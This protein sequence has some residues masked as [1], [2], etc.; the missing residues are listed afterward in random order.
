M[1]RLRVLTWCSVL[2]A[3][4]IFFFDR[5]TQTTLARGRGLVLDKAWLTNSA[6]PITP[7]EH[8]R[9]PD[10]TFLTYPEWFL[11]FGPDEQADF[12][13][14]QT[15]TRFPFMIH[16]RQIWEGYK[17]VYDQIRGNFPFN[18]GYHVMI[19]VIA[20]SSTAEF[21]LKA[22]YETLI[23]RL[24]DTADG[25]EMTKE[26][27]FNA[28]FTRDYVDFIETVPWYEFDFK[29]RL[30]TFWTETSLFGEHP[31]R[32]WER[33]YILTSELA[34]KWVY[35]WL[36]GLGTRTAY[37]RPVLSTAVVVDHLS[38]GLQ[39]RLP[40]LNIITN[41]PDSSVL[42]T[43]PRYAP[44][45][46]N[47]CELA[48]AGIAFKEIAGN[49]SAILITVLAPRDW[50]SQSDEFQVIFTQSVPTRPEIHRVALA[51]PVPLL[52]KTLHQLLEAKIQIEHLYDF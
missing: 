34:V 2:F 31:L 22:I 49:T 45:S 13:Q 30:R 26:D 46:S 43:L 11:V 39:S 18:G 41:L 5:G 27:R 40:D 48:Q 37:E 9:P 8:R 12:F 25:E 19:V 33:K 17:V 24:T 1:T 3:A 47:A 6:M 23:G 51:T 52:H 16:V 4:L 35:G 28:K 10:Q 32:K 20:T 7:T 15:S 44:F 50:A 14:T 38:P 21:G 36:I 42:I 29:S